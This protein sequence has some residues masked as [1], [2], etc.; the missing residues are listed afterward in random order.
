MDVQCEWEI[1]LSAINHWKCE[2]EY[3]YLYNL[4]ICTDTIRI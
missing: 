4:A 3:V 1:N 2:F